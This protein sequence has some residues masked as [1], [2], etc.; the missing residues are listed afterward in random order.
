MLEAFKKHR[1]AVDQLSSQ[2]VE[3]MAVIDY[4]VEN[5]ATLDETPRA[6]QSTQRSL[7]VER[8][9]AGRIGRGIKSLRTMIGSTVQTDEK[10]PTA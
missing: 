8:E 1:Q 3:N 9:L 10:N 5:V 6:A 4:V 7:R 2:A